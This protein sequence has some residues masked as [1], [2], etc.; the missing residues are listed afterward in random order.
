M[1]NTP[2]RRAGNNQGSIYRRK[3]DGRWVGS[4]SL[5]IVD[6]KRQRKTVYGNTQGEVR[7]KV[8]ELQSRLDRGIP[9]HSSSPTV[10]EFLDQWL[11]GVSKQ[12]RRPNTIE[13]YAQ[14]LNLHLKPAL[15]RYRVDKL[16]QHHVQAMLDDM[17]ERGLSLASVG[18]YR[19]ILRAALSRA[20]KHDLVA[21]NVAT[22]VDLPTPKKTKRV[23]LSADGAMQLLRSVHGDRL[24]ALYVVAVTL[25]MRQGET[26]GLQWDDI[27]L[28]AGT[29]AVRRQLY[30]VGGTVMFGPPKS[31]SGERV[32]P[33]PA[34]VITV[35]RQHRKRQ[36]EERLA[37]GGRW[38]DQWRLVFCSETGSPILATRL[39]L[40]FYEVLEA[41]DLPRMRWHDLRHSTASILATWGV[42]PKVV[43]AILGHADAS[44][45]IQTY[46]HADMQAI[47]DAAD[48]MGTLFDAEKQSI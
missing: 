43:Q 9:V 24:E 23:T 34:P 13:T 32:I 7:K 16:T 2:K 18:L 45:T 40:M 1:T 4:V 8:T 26:L 33:I 17:I 6:G 36:L 15:G 38:Q 5:G 14:A 29:I 22:L 27:D 39:R 42:H 21:R 37:A 25:G 19:S 11:E 10:A 48:R 30:K 46:T 28:E 31:A 47:R 35:L 3:S 20:M 12:G 41:A 44:L